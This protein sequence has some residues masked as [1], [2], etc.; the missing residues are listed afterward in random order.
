MSLQAFV[1]RDESWVEWLRGRIGHHKGDDP[2]APVTVVTP[3]SYVGLA[4]RHELSRTGVINVRTFVLGRLAKTVGAPQL[5]TT[6]KRPL[7]TAS[8]YAVIRRALEEVRPRAFEPVRGSPMLI[9]ALRR[10]FMDLRAHRLDD[11]SSL[12]GLRGWGLDAATERLRHGGTATERPRYGD[13]ATGGPR[14]GKGAM[15]GPA[16]GG[17]EVLGAAIDVFRCWR[18]LVLEYGRYDSV[19]LLDAAAREGSS[20][21]KLDLGAMVVA[22]PRMLTPAEVALLRALAIQVA[23]DV[24][25]R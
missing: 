9:D 7:T 22:N 18:A 21:L 19:D 14:Y 1:L 8:E 16:Y 10:L 17:G 15:E 4:W 2:L 23:V 6:R 5:A 20:V 25:W 11:D 13:G 12:D 3:N 24:A